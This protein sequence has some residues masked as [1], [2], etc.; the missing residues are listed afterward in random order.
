[1]TETQLRSQIGKAMTGKSIRGFAKEIGVSA[2]YLSRVMKESDPDPIYDGLAA[3]FGYREKK[4]ERV[5]EKIPK[6]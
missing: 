3:K 2:G 5:F 4:Q 1:M 6:K